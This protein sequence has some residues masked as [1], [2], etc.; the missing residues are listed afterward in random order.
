M[1]DIFGITPVV[2]WYSPLLTDLECAIVNTFE[3]CE[4]SNQSWTWELVILIMKNVNKIYT[5]FAVLKTACALH[6]RRVLCKCVY[7]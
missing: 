1:M 5:M 6:V 4:N 3:G 2:Y 7:T